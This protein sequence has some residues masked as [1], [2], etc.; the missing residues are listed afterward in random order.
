MYR[1]REMYMPAAEHVIYDMYKHIIC[2]CTYAE[3]PAVLLS[4]EQRA[5]SAFMCTCEQV[6]GVMVYKCMNV[7]EG[8]YMMFA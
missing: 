4:L 7:H 2:A 3:Q 5:A 6:W 1:E 8:L